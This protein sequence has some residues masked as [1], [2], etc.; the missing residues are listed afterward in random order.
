MKA[1]KIAS[2]G[3]AEV[4]R[5][6][7]AE[8]K[9]SPAAGQALVKIH[10]AGVNFVDIY[11]RRGTYPVKLPFIPGLEASGVVEAVGEKT[12]GVPPET[13]SPTPGTSGA[14]ASI[15]PLIPKG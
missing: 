13:G 11:Q 12:R 1:I 3:E 7:E 4:L 15:L 6:S 9:P 8:P 14:T 10:A 2:Y 5:F